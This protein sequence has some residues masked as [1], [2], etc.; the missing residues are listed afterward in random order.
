[1]SPVHIRVRSISQAAEDLQRIQ[2]RAE[3]EFYK[4]LSLEFGQQLE[5]I[6]QNLT[7]GNAV[8]IAIGRKPAVVAVRKRGKA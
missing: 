2:L 8:S 6:A 4:G 5:S 3:L 7:D 1:M